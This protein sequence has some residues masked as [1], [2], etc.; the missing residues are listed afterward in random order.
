MP[1]DRDG[2]AEEDNESGRVGWGWGG[3][4]EEDGVG[5]HGD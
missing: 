4:D 5:F 2:G 3:E 1:A